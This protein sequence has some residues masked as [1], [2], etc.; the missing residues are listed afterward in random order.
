MGFPISE[1]AVPIFHANLK[2]FSRGKA[3]SS[4]AAAAYRAGID[5]L[6]TKTREWHRYSRKRG[7]VDSL[8]LAPPGAPK[9][10]YEPLAFWDI[11]EQ[12]E[13]RKNARVARELEVSLPHELCAPE[14]KALAIALGQI[15]VDRYHCAV[16]VAIHEPSE[17]GD[18]RNHHTHLLMSARQVG[19][20]GL[21]ERAGG[22]LDASGGR[23]ANELARLREVVGGTINAHLRMAGLSLT[24]DH[25]SL[26]NQAKAALE[27]GDHAAAVL[28]TRPPTQHIGKTQTALD[29]KAAAAEAAEAQMDAA[30]AE[31]AGRGA[32]APTPA[33]HSHQAAFGE[34]L[35]ARRENPPLSA[36]VWGRATRPRRA[37]EHSHLALRLSRLGRIARAQGGAGA[38]VLNAEAELIEAWLDNMCKAAEEAINSARPAGMPLEVEE[39][40]A[41]EAL[42]VPRVQ[43]YGMTPFFFED[44]ETFSWS[45][46]N[47][48]SELLR[49]HRNRERLWRARAR[50]SEAENPAEPAAPRELVRARRALVKAKASVS[51][52][53]LR[54]GESR[55]AMARKAMVATRIDYEEKFHITKVEPLVPDLVDGF[56]F[57]TTGAEAM[58]GS[59]R[60]Q[61]KPRTRSTFG[62]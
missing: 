43:V 22:E 15:L 10:C 57:G 8:M 39:S 26:K 5:L 9:W 23:G 4:I 36:I 42:R 60:R 20:T 2:N 30:I 48:A 27:R 31:A 13:T 40:R 18:T 59:H 56:D 52:V 49:P 3:H 58:S 37:G 28:L 1:R 34:R 24:V 21:G 45:I 29:R 16:L 55:L 50:L 61:L 38:E 41:L 47:Y 12:R 46:Q 53:A 33:G 17:E 62:H 35:A 32:L 54:E 11:N 44:T 25:R 51:T 7:V 14:R 19:P 6:D